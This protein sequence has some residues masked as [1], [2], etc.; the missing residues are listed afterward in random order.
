MTENLIDQ[1]GLPDVEC[2]LLMIYGSLGI[3]NKC[4]VTVI[5]RENCLSIHELKSKWCPELGMAEARKVT[6]LME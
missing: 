4:S 6:Q 3:S 2:G 1:D 5:E